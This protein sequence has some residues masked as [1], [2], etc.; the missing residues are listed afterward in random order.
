M[1]TRN[2]DNSFPWAFAPPTSLSANEDSACKPLYILSMVAGGGE[3]ERAPEVVC[4]P[5][6]S[7]TAGM[8]WALLP[9]LGTDVCPAREH[10]LELLLC[11]SGFL[12]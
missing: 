7:H 2:Q 9:C 6:E 5:P 10:I 3:L 4:W 1:L 12:A 8:L 11:K